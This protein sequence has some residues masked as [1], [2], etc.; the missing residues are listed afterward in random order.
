M[1]DVGD[2]KIIYQHFTTFFINIV[3]HY[4]NITILE[5]PFF[6]SRFDMF[7]HRHN[8]YNLEEHLNI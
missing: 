5:V 8:Y 7:F 1:V 4:V 6:D 2:N 3:F